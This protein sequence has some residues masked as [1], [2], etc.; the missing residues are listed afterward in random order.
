MANFNIERIRFRWTGDWLV[1]TDYVKD[2]VV[3][4]QGKT[5][6]CLVG[7][8]SDASVIYPDLN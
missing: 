8:Q 4:Y 2:D 1:S 6:V 7:H 5:Y 3:R